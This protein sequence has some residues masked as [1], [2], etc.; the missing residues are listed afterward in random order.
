[1]K[2]IF[3][4]Y[5]DQNSYI[6]ILR[7]LNITGYYDRK[8][9]NDEFIQKYALFGGWI[10]EDRN[11]RLEIN[12][13]TTSGNLVKYELIGSIYSNPQHNFVYIYNKETRESLRVDELT[14]LRNEIPRDKPWNLLYKQVDQSYVDSYPLTQQINNLASISHEINT[15][16]KNR[17]NKLN[18]EVILKL[19]KNK[20]KQKVC[21]VCTLI[22]KSNAT[23]CT[24]CGTNL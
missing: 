6:Q 19:I 2:K 23:K 17:L 3:S 9:I 12:I 13:K 24:A 7:D 10:T 5:S 4:R 14:E 18:H 15:V 20:L 11:V 8:P 22:N 16:G 1:M 21:R